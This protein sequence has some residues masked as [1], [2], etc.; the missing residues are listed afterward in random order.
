MNSNLLRKLKKIDVVVASHIFATG[1]AL[2]LEEYLKDKVKTLFFIGH[3]FSYRK[4]TN[5]FYRFYKKG[6]LQKEY[7]AIDWKLPMP[8]FYFRDAFYTLWW[9]MSG[10]HKFDLFVGSDNL[11]SFLGLILKKIG[12]VKKVILYTIDY[13]PQRFENPIL[14]YLYHFFDKHC[15]KHCN[16]VWNVSDRIE[17]ARREYKGIGGK[18]H[19]RQIVVRLGIWYKRIPKL[20]FSEK[21]RF[22]IVFLGHLLEKQGLQLV[23]KALPEVI[24]EIPKARLVVVGTGPYEERLKGLA[25]KLRVGGNVNFL[26]YVENHKDVEKILSESVLAVAPYKPEKGS[27][28]YYADPG[29]IKN[30]LAAGLPVVLT[31]IP[32]IAGEIEEKKCAMIC[33]YSISDVSKC[34]IRFLSNEEMIKNYSKNARNYARLFDWN[35]IFGEALSISL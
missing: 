8:F 16:I 2:E 13:M 6:K 34:I 9:T 4:E 15:L 26:G 10:K 5:S 35:K 3:P 32:K 17:K 22:Q 19:G 1:P 28:T 25:R 29:K 30:Y 31:D 12:K 18:G 14:N 11:L 33:K 7:K 27:F 24:K 20:P 21:R 23:I